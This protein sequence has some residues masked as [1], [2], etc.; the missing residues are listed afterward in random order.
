MDQ[1]YTLRMGYG[2]YKNENSPFLQLF[3]KLWFCKLLQN[4]ES[5]Y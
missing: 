3:K 1:I 4:S 5:I 2:A